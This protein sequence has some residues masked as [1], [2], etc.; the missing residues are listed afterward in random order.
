M[1][2]HILGFCYSAF[3]GFWHF[4]CETTEEASYMLAHQHKT[5]TGQTDLAEVYAVAMNQII[6]AAIT[7]SGR[8]EH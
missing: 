5:Q 1:S 4:S 2:I 7:N 6:P 3:L 8:K